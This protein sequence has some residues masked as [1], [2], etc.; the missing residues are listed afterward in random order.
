MRNSS[1]FYENKECE[2]YPC[3]ND[4]EKLNCLFCY[5]PLY[6]MEHCL[7]T[8]KI[9][10]CDGKEVRDCS[11]CIY[12]HQAENYDKIIEILAPEYNRNE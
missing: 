9:I 11:Q 4:I 1:R 3:H 7:G 12:P 8:P 2:Y 6:C 10:F 5:C